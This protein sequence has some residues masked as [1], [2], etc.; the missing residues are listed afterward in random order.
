MYSLPCVFGTERFLTLFYKLKARAFIGVL[1]GNKKL[2][3]PDNYLLR[4]LGGHTPNRLL[5]LALS[6]ALS[7]VLR[8]NAVVPDLCKFRQSR[9][10][11]RNKPNGLFIQNRRKAAEFR[12]TGV[13]I[14]KSSNSCHC[15]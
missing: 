11:P 4:S 15:L 6:I 3:G 7:L 13:I 5:H 1:G 2:I 8:Q 10:I 12:N 9:R 14:K